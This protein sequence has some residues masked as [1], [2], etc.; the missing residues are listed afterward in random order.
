MNI[1]SNYHKNLN[2]YNATIMQQKD[3]VFAISPFFCCCQAMVLEK[4]GR[5]AKG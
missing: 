3:Y 2:L 5:K 1:F 4:R